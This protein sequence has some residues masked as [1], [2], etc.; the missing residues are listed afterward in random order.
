MPNRQHYEHKLAE[1]YQEVAQMGHILVS[2][3]HELE[4]MMRGAQSEESTLTK[5][6]EEEEH[7]NS[8][9]LQLEDKFITFIATEQPVA[10]DLRKIVS[11]IKIVSHWERMGDYLLH[12]ANKYVKMDHQFLPT[13]LPRFIRMLETLTIMIEGT[14]DAYLK[15]DV[16]K[17]EEIAAL[18]DE[19]DKEHKLYLK[20]LF[21]TL[22]LPGREKEFAR[23][24]NLGR[25]FERIGDHITNICE[26]IVYA[27]QFR[28][29]ELNP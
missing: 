16:R 10:H 25:S 28:H 14:L 4:S 6:Q 2:S 17:A 9:E 26:W 15:N 12:I 7:I 3:I 20:D 11:S 19:I 23:S 29:V 8:L 24:L 18:D 1:I 21:Q 27:E 13:Y 22:R 5:I